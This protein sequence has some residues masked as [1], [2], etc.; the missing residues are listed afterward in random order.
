MKLDRNRPCRA[1]GGLERMY[2]SPRSDSLQVTNVP[3][4]TNWAQAGFRCVFLK[5]LGGVGLH[6]QLCLQVRREGVGLQLDRRAGRDNSPERAARPGPVAP[7]PAPVPPERPCLGALLLPFLGAG[8]LRRRG[9]PGLRWSCPL[10]ETGPA[11]CKTAF[12]PRWG[13]QEGRKKF[14]DP[15]IIEIIVILK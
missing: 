9:L 3:L 11:P 7:G 4:L 12:I 5:G 6:S 1:A 10:P 15:K 13:Q 14:L 8:F 2:Q